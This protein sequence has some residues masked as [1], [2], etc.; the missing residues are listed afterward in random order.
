M[1]RG[2]RRWV[3]KLAEKAEV[4]TNVISDFSLQLGTFS[5]EFRLDI[6]SSVL[7]T[8]Q[9]SASDR[10]G[11]VYA[12]AEIWANDG[13]A[14][15]RIT[16]NAEPGN[17]ALTLRDLTK[18]LGSPPSID[19]IEDLVPR[20]EVGRWMRGYWCRLRE[21][22]GQPNDES[23]YDL[24]AEACDLLEDGGC[25]AIYRYHGEPIIEASG[26]GVGVSD[27]LYLWSS[28]EP[29]VVAAEVDKLRKQIADLIL[30][31]TQ[32]GSAG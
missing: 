9:F 28:F 21:D 18:S 30:V 6:E 25:L 12:V 15:D 17:L 22:R 1:A 20:G 11:F 4:N 14:Q 24:L 16:T 7:K 5:L 31:H 2:P 13:R 19:G 3:P 27:P 23:T 26:Q 8:V 29:E 10:P 32:S